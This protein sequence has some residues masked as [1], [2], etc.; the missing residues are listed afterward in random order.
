MDR[1]LYGAF[2]GIV[3]LIVGTIISIWRKID[4]KV[5]Y[6]SCNDKHEHQAKLNMEI[7][8]RLAKVE[9]KIDVGFK[10]IGEKIDN[11]RH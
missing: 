5:N 1:L 7:I 10:N 2:T 9:T 11:G 3:L 6:K 8:E 4:M